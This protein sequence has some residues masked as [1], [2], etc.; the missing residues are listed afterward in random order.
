[1]I[2]KGILKSSEW[3]QRAGRLASRFALITDDHVQSIWGRL[4]QE[5]LEQ[6]GFEVHVLTVPPG[7][8]SKTRSTKERLEDQMLA[9]GLG[10]DAAVIALGGGVVTDLAGFV[11]ATYCR[12]IPWIAI[13]TTLMGMIDA[14]IGGK[15]GVNTP[16]GKN[17]IGAFYPPANHIADLETLSTLPRRELLSGFSEM[18][19]Y[20]LIGSQA[21][22]TSLKRS[23]LEEAISIE[24]IDSCITMKRKITSLDPFEK[25]LRRTLNFGHTVGHA[26]ETASD[27]S[28][29]H[30]EAIALG[31]IVEAHLSYQM[32][33]LSQSDQEAVAPIFTH[34]G[35]S[36]E[37]PSHIHVEHLIAIMKRDKKA[38]GALPRFVLLSA[39]GSVEAFE[40]TYCS[41]VSESMLQESLE[42]VFEE[43]LC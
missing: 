5:Q 14:S 24:N 41:F 3:L 40:G 6:K 39:I 4:L 38:K 18:I 8:E 25:G 7:E 10:R 27:Y 35:F 26:L 15:V 17:M 20:A 30:G 29:S 42:W 31:M 28:L 12:G 23:N 16:L 33:L 36:L 1:M 22:F 19:K 13:P 2:E 32:G 21:L 11:A 34:Y 9:R 43:C 37:I